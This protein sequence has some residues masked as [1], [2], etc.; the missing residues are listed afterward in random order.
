MHDA[1]EFG[2]C[3]APERLPW[4]AH[5]RWAVENDVLF[6][7]DL[8]RDAYL[9]VPMAKLGTP[10][11][12]R[13]LDA[14]GLLRSAEDGSLAKPIRTPGLGGAGL[15]SF[16]R[17]AL[18]AR[19]VM[20]RRALDRATTLLQGADDATAAGEHELVVRFQK[21]RP[22]YPRAASCLFD[23]LALGRFLWG[24]GVRSNLIYAVRGGPFSA[25]AWLEIGGVVINDDAEY[26]AGFTVMRG[27]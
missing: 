14:R 1:V 26:C 9:S 13:Q 19:N 23:S 6:V 17:A 11:L 7:L 22:L 27:P 3:E 10:A 25:H 16:W 2:R 5:A 24:A 8:R 18:W 15:W 20:K 4:A 12:Q 21:W